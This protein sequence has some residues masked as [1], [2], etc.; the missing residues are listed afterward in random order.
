MQFIVSPDI[1]TEAYYLP[2]EDTE[3]IKTGVWVQDFEEKTG[4]VVH[5]PSTDQVLDWDLVA[6]HWKYQDPA[7]LISL[8]LHLL[9]PYR[10]ELF[11]W[12]WKQNSDNEA[13][14]Q[15]P[16]DEAAWH[17]LVRPLLRILK[18]PFSEA[19]EEEEFQPAAN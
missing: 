11:Q 16:F 17:L 9:K 6:D 8:H 1:H 2:C 10:V 13:E 4:H 14:R 3:D 15:G 7:Q 5:K 12:L 19:G 18:I